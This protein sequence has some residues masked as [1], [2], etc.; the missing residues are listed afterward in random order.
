MGRLKHE[1]FDMQMSTL[2]GITRYDIAM[3]ESQW[4]LGNQNC[5]TVWFDQR[6]EN[7]NCE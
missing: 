5:G 1:Q 6:E 7:I 3:K 4:K 2:W